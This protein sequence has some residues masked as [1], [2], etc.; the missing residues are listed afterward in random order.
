MKNQDSKKGFIIPAL[1]II[2]AILLI[3]VGIYSYR[4]S[5]HNS[6]AGDLSASSTTAVPGQTATSPLPQVT[7][8]SG[9]TGTVTIGPTCGGAQMYPPKPNCD[10]QPYNGTFNLYTEAGT[11]VRTID[12]KDGKFSVTTA[13]G[14]YEIRGSGANKFPRVSQAVTVKAHV[15]THVNMQLDSGIR[16]P[17]PGPTTN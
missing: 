9:I 4:T 6:V 1:I 15:F 8:D 14:N 7:A 2:V 17:S 10:D 11:F 3:G 16:A 12:V 13:A 5:E